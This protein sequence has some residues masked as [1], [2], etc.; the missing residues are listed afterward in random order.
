M[1]VNKKKIGRDALRL[2]LGHWRYPGWGKGFGFHW[3]GSG[4]AYGVPE[5]Y[6]RLIIKLFT[7]CAFSFVF[8]PW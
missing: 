8:K 5:G 3:Y 7:G 4:N 1:L 6:P 2:V